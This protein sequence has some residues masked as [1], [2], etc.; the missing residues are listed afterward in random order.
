MLDFPFIFIER[1]KKKEG[2]FDEAQY[3]VVWTAAG[4]PQLVTF[5]PG[6]RV[7]AGGNPERI[8][9]VPPLPP[10]PIF[11]LWLVGFFFLLLFSV[12]GPH[13]SAVV[14]QNA[15]D[16]FGDARISTHRHRDTHRQDSRGLLFKLS[17]RVP[18]WE[19]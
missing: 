16:H 7:Q 3:T 5:Q 6:P 8:S 19:A 17:P 11:Q 4:A 15:P 13:S 14:Q 1:T 18:S 12:D 9:V 2:N 10:S